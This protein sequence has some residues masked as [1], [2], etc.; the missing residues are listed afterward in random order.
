M[1]HFAGPADQGQRNCNQCEIVSP[2]LTGPDQRNHQEA[3]NLYQCPQTG[4]ESRETVNC[5]QPVINLNSVV[6]NHTHIVQGQP[7]RKGVS[8]AIVKQCQSLKYVNNASCVDQLCSVKRAP[9]VPNVVQNLPVGARLNQFWKLGKPWG[10]TQSIT[11]FKFFPDQTKLDQV[12]I[13]HQLLCTSSQESL[14][15]GGITSADKRK[16]QK[17]WSTIKNLW[18]FKMGYFWSQ[19]QSQQIP[20]GRKMQNGDTSND[21]DILTV[22]GVGHVHRFQERLLPYTHTK[23]IKEISEIS[24]SGQNIPVQST[25]IWPPW[26]SL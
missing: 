16:I 6:V 25:T 20:Q 17:S 7:Q 4:P 24:C 18:A 12:A 1:L 10:R 2:H 15:I 19:N 8:L 5:F 9:N 23:P 26:S 14:P 21:L 13:N 22:R 11:N 3:V